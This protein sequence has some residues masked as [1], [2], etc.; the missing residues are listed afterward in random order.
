MGADVKQPIT[1][2]SVATDVRG[3]SGKVA[4]LDEQMKKMAA[5]IRFMHETLIKSFNHVATKDDLAKFA[6]KDDVALCATKED[7]KR[8]A[9]K[10]DLKQFATKKDLE[11]F[12][13]KEDLKQFA[14]KEDLK[15]LK[16]E[17]KVEIRLVRNALQ[18]HVAEYKDM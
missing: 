6:T 2:E 13:T 16:H 12:A 14:T 7:L 5:D 17:L 1:L 8:F 10:E 9:T 11:R 18:G 15:S 3:L 4:S